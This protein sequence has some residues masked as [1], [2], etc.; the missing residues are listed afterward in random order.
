[1]ADS[2]L[3]NW[4]SASPKDRPERSTANSQSKTSPKLKKA[5]YN[6]CSINCT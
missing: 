4:T 3:A 6:Q 1:M 2:R 5:A